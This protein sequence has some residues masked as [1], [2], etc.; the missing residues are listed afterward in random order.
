MKG[1][2]VGYCRC[3]ILFK[4]TVNHENEYFLGII[5]EKHDITKSLEVRFLERLYIVTE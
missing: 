3:W 2:S 1:D 5:L 4:V